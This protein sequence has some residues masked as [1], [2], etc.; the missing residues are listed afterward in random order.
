VLWHC[1]LGIRTSSWHVKNGVVRCWH[2]YLSGARCKWFAYGP[3]DATATPSSLASLIS[4]KFVHTF[5]VP[6]YPGSPG[7]QA[8]KWVSCKSF[9]VYQL[10]KRALGN[11]WSHSCLSSNSTKAP[12]EMLIFLQQ[13]TIYL[14][15][16]EWLLFW[17]VLYVRWLGSHSADVCRMRW[18]VRESCAARELKQFGW[19]L[20]DFA[21]EPNSSRLGSEEFSRVLDT[22]LLWTANISRSQRSSGSTPDCSVTGHSFESHHGK[23]CSSEQPLQYTA[24][25]TGCIPLQNAVNVFKALSCITFIFFF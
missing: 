25:G 2:G 1:W 8:I 3:A 24:L 23:L 14:L 11:N 19:F 5:L 12:K 10:W 9:R 18:G 13:F 20:P 17:G 15:L 22:L 6:A 21:V 4:R 16:P 7:K